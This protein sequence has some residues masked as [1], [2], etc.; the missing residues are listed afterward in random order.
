MRGM[1]TTRAHAAVTNILRSTFQT[2]RTDV[3]H[4]ARGA[5]DAC[6]RCRYGSH[7][8]LL[9]PQAPSAVS[10]CP[11]NHFSRAYIRTDQGVQCVQH[12]AQLSALTHVW[13]MSRAMH[14][15]L[16]FGGCG[17]PLMNVSHRRKRS[18][19]QLG[20]LCSN[21]IGRQP[22]QARHIKARG[23][24]L[25]TYACMGSECRIRM[26]RHNVPAAAQQQRKC[27]RQEPSRQ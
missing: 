12:A 10:R 1:R 17:M 7:H 6:D 2:P 14:G 5:C 16:S 20:S 21:G 4:V 9:S 19:K 25:S 13:R 24:S 23:A 8:A 27:L 22:A 3:S 11:A 26:L 18:L 15:W